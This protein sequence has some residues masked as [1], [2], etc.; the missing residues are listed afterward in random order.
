MLLISLLF[1]WLILKI[2]TAGSAFAVYTAVPVAVLIATFASVAVT[3]VTLVWLLLL[4]LLQLFLLL[5][6][7][8]NICQRSLFVLG[9]GDK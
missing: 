6:L 2:F 3:A 7:A 4:L 1:L 9:E 8:E 5:L